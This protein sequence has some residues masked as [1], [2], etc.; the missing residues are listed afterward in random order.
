MSENNAYETGPVSGEGAFSGLAIMA[1]VIGCLFIVPGLGP[2]AL[3]LGIVAIVKI[4][5]RP[6]ELRG[7]GLAIAA[8][9]LGAVGTVLTCVAVVAFMVYTSLS[10]TLSSAREQARATSS[11]N[12]LKQLG[13]GCLL[14]SAD[15]GG[16]Y[17]PNIQVLLDEG[18]LKDE[19]ILECPREGLYYLYVPNLRED[20][21][22]S[23]ILMYEDG[24]SEVE[25]QIA[26]M[27]NALYVDG[28]VELV[29]MEALEG[30]GGQ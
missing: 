26:N 17:S 11:K 12:N 25:S 22:P 16:A 24:E 3:V 15:N 2:V 7:N 20:L 30:L 14:Y 19:L 5:A 1:F 13:I 23:T 4:S 27:R 6:D 29:P 28:H 21:D 8:T 9:A 10:P 18:Y